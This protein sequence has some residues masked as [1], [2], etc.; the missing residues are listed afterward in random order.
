[1]QSLMVSISIIRGIRY[2]GVPWGRRCLSF[3][4]HLE[5]KPV[6]W[7]ANHRGRERLKVIL[8]WEV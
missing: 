3:L 1:M 7:K 8:R 6:I 2:I 4:F 5:I